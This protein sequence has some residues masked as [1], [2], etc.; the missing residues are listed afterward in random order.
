MRNVNK[1]FQITEKK[2][3]SDS[4]CFK[5]IWSTDTE[6]WVLAK[7]GSKW[8]H[9]VVKEPYLIVSVVSE[10]SIDPLRCKSTKK[11]LQRD[12]RYES[13]LCHAV[14]RNHAQILLHQGSQW[15]NHRKNIDWICLF[16]KQFN[17]FYNCC[18][19]KIISKY[20]PSETTE[21]S[22]ITGLT[23][24]HAPPCHSELRRS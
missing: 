14:K 20:I 2:H 21:N 4:G 10:N 22:I 5:I 18:K 13:Y 16:Y 19:V 17:V 24:E 7:I 15:V 9:D 1:Y 12:K 6:N 8:P 11:T 23:A 3:I